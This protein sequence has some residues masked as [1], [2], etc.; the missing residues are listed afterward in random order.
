M[1]LI[2][3]ILLASIAFFLTACISTFPDIYHKTENEEVIGIKNL[4]PKVLMSLPKEYNRKEFTYKR[5]LKDGVTSY[6]VYYEKDGVKFTNNYDELG[7]LVRKEKKIKLSDIPHDTRIKIV[8]FLSQHYPGYKTLMVEEV[9]AHNE[10]LV[11]IFFSHPK[12]KT[13]LIEAVFEYQT[14]IFRE[15]INIRMKSI[16]T[17]ND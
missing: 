15:S 17:L 10:M 13:G 9:Y 16:Q 2:M 5:K 6:D 1:S 4:P 7:K 12:T 8:E 11:E 3:K 14:G